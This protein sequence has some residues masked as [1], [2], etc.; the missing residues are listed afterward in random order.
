MGRGAF[1]HGQ[2]YVALSRCRTLQGITLR[3]P[4]QAKDMIVDE[5]VERFAGKFKIG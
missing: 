5:A 3:T 2:L 1:A 4:I